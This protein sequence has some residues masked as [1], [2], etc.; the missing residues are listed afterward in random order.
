MTK[1][2]KS[3][4]LTTEEREE[5]E[6]HARA[7]NALPIDKSLDSFSKPDV[8][9][10]SYPDIRSLSLS[11]L[12]EN[13]AVYHSTC[14]VSHDGIHLLRVLFLVLLSRPPILR[15]RRCTA[16]LSLEI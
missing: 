2:D 9:V 11:F 5:D 12:L 10:I 14:N 13:S 4:K 15:P 6:A 8:H 7:D 16:V 1:R 3:W